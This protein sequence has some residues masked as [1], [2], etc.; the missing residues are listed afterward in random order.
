MPED[1][2]SAA[3]PDD[4]DGNLPLPDGTAAAGTPATEDA[5]AAPAPDATSAGGAGA[6]G[7]NGDAGDG[8]VAA[9]S[10]PPHTAEPVEEPPVSPKY[11]PNELVT[12]HG[13]KSEKAAAFNGREGVILGFIPA[14]KKYDAL[15]GGKT[16]IMVKGENLARKETQP[17]L[18]D[19]AR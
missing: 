12:I 8:G 1:E 17:S 16:R 6:D 5:A 19:C 7:A 9:A 2:E 10:S 4:G 13:L 11:K 14:T 15:I 3:S 18:Q